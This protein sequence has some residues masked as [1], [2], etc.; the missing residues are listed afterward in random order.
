[1]EK[2]GCIEI[3]RE[4]F[5]QIPK[6]DVN[7]IT[8]NTM[9]AGYSSIGNSQSCIELFKKMNMEGIEPSLTTLSSIIMACSRSANFG[10]G[11]SHMVT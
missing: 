9:I 7:V 2:C 8:W 10:M 1:M 6:K 11:N 4:V 5:E 3:A